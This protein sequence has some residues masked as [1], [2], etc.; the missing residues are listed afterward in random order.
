MKKIIRMTECV[1]DSQNREMPLE[2]TIHKSSRLLTDYFFGDGHP[3][4]ERLREK[5]FDEDIEARRIKFDIGGYAQHIKHPKTG[6][7]IVVFT[8]TELLLWVTM[9]EHR[10]HDPRDEMQTMYI[11]GKLSEY[12]NEQGFNVP[13]KDPNEIEHFL[14]YLEQYIPCI[15][16]YFKVINK[17]DKEAQKEDIMA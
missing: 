7:R 2:H 17:D 9:N 13:C 5:V 12:I 3:L 6:K 1:F 4:R 14:Q 8:V 10:E 11:Q 15:W 16:D